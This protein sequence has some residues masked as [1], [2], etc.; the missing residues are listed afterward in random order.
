M[1]M[2]MAFQFQRKLHPE[3]YV[4]VGYAALDVFS[5]IE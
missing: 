3:R 1:I 4:W 2:E 5:G